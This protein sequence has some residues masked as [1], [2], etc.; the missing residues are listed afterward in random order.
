MSASDF[1]SARIVLMAGH[2]AHHGHSEEKGGLARLDGDT[3]PHEAC[4]ANGRYA[5]VVAV[6]AA[7]HQVPPVLNQRQ[8]AVEV[9]VLR[10]T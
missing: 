1:N 2:S 4:R 3:A 9:E 10:L 7:L 8:R 5:L 6:G